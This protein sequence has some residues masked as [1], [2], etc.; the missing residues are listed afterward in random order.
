MADHQNSHRKRGIRASRAKLT[1]ALTR[2]GLRTQAA[3]AGHIADL[4]GLDSAPKDV[5][6]RAFRELPVELQTLERIASALD[7]EAHTLYMTADESSAA[8]S[9]SPHERSPARPKLVLAPALIALLGIFVASAITWQ[10]LANGE[11]GTASHVGERGNNTPMLSLGSR[12]LVVL[13]LKGDDSGELSSALRDK[14]QEHFTVAK[15]SADVLTDSLDPKAAAEKLRTDAAVDGEIVTV[16]RLS[17]VRIFLYVQGVRQQVWAESLP[18]VALSDQRENIARRI[19]LA[20]QRMTDDQESTGTAQ[21]F[22]L[23]PV[24]DNYLEG[25]RQL[26]EPSNEL[27]VRRALSRFEAALRQDANFARAHAGLCQALLEE[28]WMGD[29]QRALDD[30]SRACGQALQLN[31]NDPV[32]ATAHAHF[33]RRTGKNDEA[34][35]LYEAVIDSHPLDAAAWNGL[36]SSRLQAFRQDDDPAM[37]AQAKMA[38]RAAADAD[39]YVWK[40]LFSLA[41]MEWFDGNIDGAIAASESALSRHENEYVLG[42]LGTF[43]L[44]K[45]GYDKARD[46]Y[47]RAGEISPQSYI[48]DEFLGQ[49]YYYLGDFKESARLRQRAIDKIGAGAPEIHEMWGNLGDSYRQIGDKN[50]AIDAYLRA[51]EIL[52]RDYLR[53]TSPASDQATRAFYYT[54]LKDLDPRRVPDSVE[55]EIVADL[56][57][58]SQ[59]LTDTSAN[60]RM[61]QTWLARGEPKKAAASLEKATATCK[62]YGGFP[63]LAELRVQSD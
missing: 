60:R 52:E 51:A 24:Q 47:L 18:T 56:D 50:A 39:P 55:R 9:R 35:A 31:S 48:G 22:P 49:A 62:G 53:G 7:V 58:V 19:A 20:I 30:A 40:P 25:E 14:L 5:V 11:S 38:A 59:A 41:A 63:D 17:G 2:A 1:H 28:H 12:S 54:M 37:L 21:Y 61:A 29:E 16:G 27:N 4:E 34:I 43:Y 36:A 23:A 44:C 15:G 26:D 45:G 10:F 42:N 6:N 8:D 57:D 13:P 46:A 33:L 32:V 3:L